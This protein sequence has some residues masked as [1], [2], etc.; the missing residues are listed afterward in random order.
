MLPFFN[1]NLFLPLVYTLT[2]I[3]MLYSSF[4]LFRETHLKKIIAYSSIVHMNIGIL[5]LFSN[6]LM[7]IMGGVFMMFSH[8]FISAGLFFCGGVIFNRFKS[9]DITTIKN[10]SKTMPKFSL[11]VILLIFANMGLP[12]TSGFIGEFLVLFG[13]I[14][15]NYFMT[16]ILLV[17]LLLNTVYNIILL[18][19]ILYGN[20]L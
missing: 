11:F 12:L 14:K 16:F 10:L 2:T 5:G 8:S 17:V 15:H 18:S 6:N 1:N 9:Y 13:V 3:S 20:I 4:I 7:G 19:R